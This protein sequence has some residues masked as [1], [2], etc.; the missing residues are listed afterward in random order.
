VGLTV[1]MQVLT[2]VVLMVGDQP[3]R[4]LCNLEYVMLILSGAQTVHT[5]LYALERCSLD[6]THCNIVLNCITA[7]QLVFFI[8]S[9]LLCGLINI[10]VQT[11]HASEPQSW[12]LMG[13]FG[14]AP[15]L[16]FHH[17]YGDKLLQVQ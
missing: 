1:V 17:L 9:N 13:I 3:S 6:Q 14:M 11:L 4:R 8:L 12:L 2:R 5:L 10:T 7:N 15:T 16:L